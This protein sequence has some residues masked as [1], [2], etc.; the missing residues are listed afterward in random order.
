[1][2]TSDLKVVRWRTSSRSGGGQNCVEVGRSHRWA[3]VR[4]TK[5]RATGTLVFADESFGEFLAA[6]KADR[7]G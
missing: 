1:M 4:D 2:V 3:A 5:S 7:L 6:V